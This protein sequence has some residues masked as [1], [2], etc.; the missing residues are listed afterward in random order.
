MLNNYTHPNGEDS[1]THE[2]PLNQ[3]YQTLFSLLKTVILLPS[4]ILNRTS[5][6]ILEKKAR[7]FK[8]SFSLSFQDSNY[9]PPASTSSQLCLHP[10][11]TPAPSPVSHALLYIETILLPPQTFN[12]SSSN[13]FHQLLNTHDMPIKKRTF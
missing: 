11:I 5:S 6:L 1:A 2:K 10:V 9:K 8:G 4:I 12:S 3:S 7:N 13:F